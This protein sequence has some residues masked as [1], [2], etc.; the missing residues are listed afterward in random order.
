MGCIYGGAAGVFLGV[1]YFAN[2]TI[3]I[4]ILRRVG[5]WFRICRD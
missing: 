3:K 1:F 2:L 5:S 4:K